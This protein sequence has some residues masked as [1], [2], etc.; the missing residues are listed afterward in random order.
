MA[1]TNSFHYSRYTSRLGTTK[2]FVG[3]DR[4]ARSSSNFH[5]SFLQNK[6]G[7]SLGVEHHISQFVDLNISSLGVFSLGFAQ[8]T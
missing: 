4:N 8:F 3:V 2:L 1:R 5:F 6:L 7:F